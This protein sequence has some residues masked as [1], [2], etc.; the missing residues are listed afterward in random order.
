MTKNDTMLISLDVSS[1]STGIGIFRNG[2]YMNGLTISAIKEN[3]AY[4]NRVIRIVG[5]TMT[6]RFDNIYKELVGI[7]DTYRPSIVVAED[8]ARNGKNRE[9]VINEYIALGEVRAWCILHDAHFET[10]APARWRKL[11]C[12]DEKIPNKT[13]ETKKWAR[14]K[15]K[16]ILNIEDRPDDE[17]EAALIG[18]AYINEWTGLANRFEG[19]D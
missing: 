7:L 18:Q 13:E 8:S 14:I 15:A 6:E 16:G 19:K 11:I 2:K 1:T 12:P 9:F 5:E 17:L 10:Y 4:K 3:K